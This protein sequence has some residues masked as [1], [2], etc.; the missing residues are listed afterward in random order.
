M[1]RLQARYMAM[2]CLLISLWSAIRVAN[3]TIF[4]VLAPACI[5]LLLIAP[6]PASVPRDRDLH[7]IVESQW[8]FLVAAAV[9]TLQSAAVGEHVGKC[10]AIAIAMIAMFAM[11]TLIVRKQVLTINEAIAWLALSAAISSAFVVLQGEFRLFTSISPVFNNGTQEWLRATGLAE[12]P[13]EAGAIAGIGM[14]LAVH[15]LLNRTPTNRGIFTTLIL[16]LMVGVNAYS[17]ISSASLTAVGSVA[18]ALAAQ[19][20]LARRYGLLAIAGTAVPAVLLPYLLVSSN[21]L[22]DRILKLLTLGDQFTTVRYRQ[23]QLSETLGQ[24]D[25]SSFVIGHGYSFD[26]LPQGLEIHNALIASLYHFGVFGLLSQLLICSFLIKKLFSHYP[27]AT[28]GVLLGVLI[29]FFGEYLTG[30]V[31]SRRSDWIS[32]VVLASFMPSARFQLSELGA[33][34]R[35]KMAL[36]PHR[37]LDRGGART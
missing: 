6:A 29:V 4:D 36:G 33:K 19:L 10:A 13:I 30:P 16:I 21:L 20:M 18:A 34:Y 35:R 14:V 7:L 2:F 31:F 11:A 9:S 1:L 37:E 8:L 17:M 27:P 15:L 23:E 12:H 25:F 32:A 26:D 3:F 5:L 22:G 28:R 24:I